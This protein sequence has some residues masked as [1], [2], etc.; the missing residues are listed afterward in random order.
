MF[1]DKRKLRSKR[2][3]GSWR[4]G[5][6]DSDGRVH[7]MCSWRALQGKSK[8]EAFVW[9]TM[10]WYCPQDQGFPVISPR[11]GLSGIMGQDRGRGEGDPTGG[12][13]DLVTDWVMGRESSVTCHHNDQASVWFTVWMEVPALKWRGSERDGSGMPVRHPGG[14]IQSDGHQ[15]RA[16]QRGLGWQLGNHGRFTAVA[17][18]CILSFLL[19]QEQNS[20]FFQGSFEPS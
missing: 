4:G 1:R 3:P 6:R 7:M 19:S 8:R 16:Q 11:D 10:W 17:C 14:A 12:I 15:A 13:E 18:P 20:N 9:S 5:G 2:G